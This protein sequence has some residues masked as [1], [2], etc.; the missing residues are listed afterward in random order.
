MRYKRKNFK[1]L[2]YPAKYLK[3]D[4]VG[5]IH[6]YASVFDVIDSHQDVII[7]GS[8]ANVN[9]DK[10]KLLWQ[11]DPNLPIG[12]ITTLTEDYWGLYVEAE[13]TLSVAQARE[14]HELIKSGA[15]S[16]LSIGFNPISYINDDYNNRIIYD[17]DLW[18]ISLVT[19]P[20]NQSAGILG[21]KNDNLEDTLALLSRS[22]D[23][24]ENF[25]TF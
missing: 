24:A 21:Y 14:A 22:L 17:I 2:N 20:A 8:F 10:V 15:I 13:L 16:G 23:K 7:K 5:K 1:Q 12:K 9:V 19:F 25:L 6:G 11:H 3:S 4:N 18:E